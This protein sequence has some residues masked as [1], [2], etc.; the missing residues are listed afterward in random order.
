[1]ASSLGASER[2]RARLARLRFLLS[3]APADFEALLRRYG[4]N[5]LDDPMIRQRVKD[6]NELLLAVRRSVASRH[7]PRD[8]YEKPAV[9]EARDGLFA[10]G[11]GLVPSKLRGRRP[12]EVQALEV[13]AIRKEYADLVFLIRLA[14]HDRKDY[15]AQDSN[16]ILSRYELTELIPVGLRLKGRQ[17]DVFRDRPRAIAIA[18]ISKWESLS[19]K[20]IERHLKGHPTSATLRKS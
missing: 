10:L 15:P 14:Q 9:V 16:E 1:M 4:A 19:C 12:R 17:V 5:I 8:V 18:A 3:R 6:W 20:Q 2:A 13:D 11:R 7:L